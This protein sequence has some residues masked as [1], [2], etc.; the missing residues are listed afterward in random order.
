MLT[1]RLLGVAGCRAAATHQAHASGNASVR[2]RAPKLAKRCE[3]TLRAGVG[4]HARDSNQIREPSVSSA[5]RL[6]A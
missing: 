2:S 3:A 1:L 6:R 5:R 4:C